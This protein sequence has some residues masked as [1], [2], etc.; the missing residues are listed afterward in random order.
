MIFGS[1]IFCIENQ[2]IQNA[3]NLIKFIDLKHAVTTTEKMKIVIWW[4]RSLYLLN[5]FRFFSHLAASPRRLQ[6][7]IEWESCEGKFFGCSQFS[8]NPAEVAKKQLHDDKLIR[9][10]RII[11]ARTRLHQVQSAHF[12]V[13]WGQ[14][15]KKIFPSLVAVVYKLISGPDNKKFF[16]P[17]SKSH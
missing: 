9:P 11:S 1:D 8:P 15:G 3:A 6:P 10:L 17:F 16:H 2:P 7:M 14:L 13:G 4:S 12:E 5:V